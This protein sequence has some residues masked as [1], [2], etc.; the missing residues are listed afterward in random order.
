MAEGWLGRAQ[1]AVEGVI[2]K[3]DPENDNITRIKDVSDKDVLA[4]IEGNWTDKVYYS[5]GS[6]PVSKS[7][8]CLV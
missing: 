1:N 4:R 2:Y 3:F 8:V 6:G 7:K 5:L